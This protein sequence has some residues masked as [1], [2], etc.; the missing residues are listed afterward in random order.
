[1]VLARGAGLLVL[2][3]QLIALWCPLAAAAQAPSSR[4]FLSSSLIDGKNHR[5]TIFPPETFFWK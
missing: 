2:L 4:A 5:Q 3:V 1:M